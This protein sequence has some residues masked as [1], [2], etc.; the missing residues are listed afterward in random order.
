MYGVREGRSPDIFE[1]KGPCRT[2]PSDHQTGPYKIR[3][4]FL[5]ARATPLLPVVETYLLRRLWGAAPILGVR[6]F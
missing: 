6:K 3:L 5:D 4:V 2:E 1:T